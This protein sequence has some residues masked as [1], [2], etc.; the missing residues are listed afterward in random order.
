MYRGSIVTEQ[1]IT[2]STHVW[3]LSPQ[4][5]IETDHTDKLDIQSNAIILVVSC[6]LK[7]NR[8]TRENQFLQCPLGTTY[9]NRSLFL[10]ELFHGIYTFLESTEGT[11]SS[12]KPLLVFYITPYVILCHPCTTQKQKDRNKN[13]TRNTVISCFKCKFLWSIIYFLQLCS[14]QQT[15]NKSV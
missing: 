8:H 2:S 9:R 10:D 15:K 6:L 7:S 12:A 14:I 13:K 11:S 5:E 1:L 4:H 3:I